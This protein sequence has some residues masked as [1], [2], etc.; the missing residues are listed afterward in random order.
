MFTTGFNYMT[1]FLMMQSSG[2]TESIRGKSSAI[3][4]QIC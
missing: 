3:V 1:A 4:H 2:L